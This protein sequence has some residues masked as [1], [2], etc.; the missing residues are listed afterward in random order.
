MKILLFNP[1]SSASKKP[2]LP[3]SLLALG[4]LLEDVWEYSILDGNLLEDPLEELARHI[5]SEQIDVLGVTIMPGPQLNSATPLCEELKRRFPELV[6]VW[7]GYF[8]GQHQQACLESGFV[9]YVMSGC[10]EHGFLELV[11]ALAAGS[12][13]QA[14]PGLSFK[15]P[16]SGKCR[17]NP[18]NSFPHPDE[19]PDFP[20]E[21]VAVK[22]YLR[23]TFMGQRT[24]SHHSSYGCPFLCG[25]CAVATLANGQWKAQSA[26]RLVQVVTRLVEQYGADS[27]EFHDNSFFID[28]QRVAD[29]ARS[30]KHLGIGWWAEA[31]IDRLASYSDESWELMRDSGLKMVFMG[32]ESGADE[33]LAQ[34]N[35]G[36]TSS[37]QKTLYI[38]ERMKSFGVVPEFSFVLGN[39]PHPEKDAQGTFEFIRRLKEINPACEIILYMYTPVPMESELYAEAERGGFR[40]P[41]TLAEWTDPTWRDFCQRRDLDVPWLAPGLRKRARN[42]EVVLGARYPTV[43]DHR[44]KGFLRLVL[45]LMSGWRYR[46]R[47]YSFPLELYIM[48]KL[49]NY[50]RPETSG[51]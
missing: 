2:I 17:N 3:M 23:P 33:T 15:D 4:A 21:R 35:K 49:V 25:F 24:I 43:T 45:R 8:P 40:F 16:E 38:A 42:F 10:G 11:N 29:F 19:L 9:D 13:G 50:K 27:V 36:G 26:E 22:S 34:M 32:A 39:P 14:I 30:I 28:E 5:A 47:F 1:Q 31:R 41:E 20:Y 7:G 37:T 6:I 48:Q 46:L 44:L 12:S 18:P 51:L